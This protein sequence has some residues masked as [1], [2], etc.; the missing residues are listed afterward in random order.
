MVAAPA[1]FAQGDIHTVDFKNFTYLPECTGE[2]PEKITV[3][4]G[5]YVKE[6]KVDGNIDRFYFDVDA[7]VFGDLTGDGHDE[8]IIR[9]NCNTGGTG[10]F[11][12]GFVYTMRAGKPSL[13]ARIPGGDRGD[14]GLVSVKA[15]GGLLVVEANAIDGSG[16]N[17]CPQFIETSKYRIVGGKLVESGKSTRREAVPRE[18]IAF[19]KGASSKTFKTR[20]DPYMEKRFTVGAAAGQTLTVSVDLDGV[21]LNLLT[22]ELSN[23]NDAAREITVTVTIK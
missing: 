10:Q 18:R 23:G 12:E 6:T 22:F 21:T 17:C 3:K 20:I 13:L 1:S 16:G 7:P 11:T 2:K 4:A 15:V 14:G 5:S 9:S 8:A 19:D